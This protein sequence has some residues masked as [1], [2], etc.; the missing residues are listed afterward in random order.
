[1]RVYYKIVRKGMTAN[2]G[3]KAGVSYSSIR[4]EDWTMAGGDEVWVC[5]ASSLQ[6]AKESDMWR[7]LATY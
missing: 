1:M 3:R 2:G 7:M 6:D 4:P 5:R